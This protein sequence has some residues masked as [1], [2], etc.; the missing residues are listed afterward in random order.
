VEAG[1]MNRVLEDLMGFSA[2]R[3]VGGRYH[4]PTKP[5]LGFEL[6]EA[7]LKKY[8]FRGT[9]PLRAA[10][11]IGL[12]PPESIFLTQSGLHVSHFRSP[13]T[14]PPGWVQQNSFRIQRIS[15]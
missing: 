3:L 5:G 12:D 6:S 4:L 10:S 14:L 15:C 1:E 11:R 2:L 9:R 7:A 13:E 8:P